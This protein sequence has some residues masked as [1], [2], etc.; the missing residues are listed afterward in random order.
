MDLASGP[1]AAFDGAFCGCSTRFRFER[2]PDDVLAVQDE[3]IRHVVA[4]LAVDLTP[5]EQAE[6]LRRAERYRTYLDNPEASLRRERAA[7]QERIRHAHRLDFAIA[8]IEALQCAHHGNF[9]TWPS[10]IVI[11]TNMF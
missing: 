1:S 3:V 11:C 8:I 7:A 5:E 6:F 4:T 10:N 2:H 9:G